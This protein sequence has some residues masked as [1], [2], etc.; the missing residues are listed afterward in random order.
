[1]KIHPGSKILFTLEND[2]AIVRKQELDA[3]AIFER[4]A[5]KGK[6]VKHFVFHAYEELKQRE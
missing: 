2:R 1:M 6:S 4:I 3:V 5:K